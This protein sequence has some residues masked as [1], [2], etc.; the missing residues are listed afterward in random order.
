MPVCA[1]IYER[2]RWFVLKV[3]KP[4]QTGGC[5][6][7][8]GTSEHTQGERTNKQKRLHPLEAKTETLTQRMVLVCCMCMPSLSPARALLHFVPCFQTW[9]TTIQALGKKIAQTAGGPQALPRSGMCDTIK[10]YQCNQCTKDDEQK[11]LLLVQN[12]STLLSWYSKSV[13]VATQH[14]LNELVPRRWVHPRFV[15][16]FAKG[17]RL[18]FS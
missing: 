17:V 6:C 14:F 13:Q 4:T 3:R 7:E 15:E 16:T 10:V 9:A 5:E 1:S 2:E 12:K 11:D 8:V 18:R